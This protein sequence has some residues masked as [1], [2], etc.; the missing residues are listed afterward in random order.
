[1]SQLLNQFNVSNVTQQLKNP[2]VIV[3]AILVLIVLI[4]LFIYLWKRANNT[5]TNACKKLS[6]PTV[7]I[8]SI[9]AKDLH[10]HRPLHDYMIKSSYNSC[11]TGPFKHSWVSLCALNHVIQQGCRVLDFEIYNINGVPHVAASSSVD[12]FEKG[13]YNSIPFDTVIKEISTNA[14]VSRICPNPNDPLFLN[15]RI[16]STHPEIY[17]KMADSLAKYLDDRMLSNQYSYEY[18]KDGVH[19]NLSNVHLDKLVGKVMIMVDKKNINVENSRLFEYINIAGNSMFMH[20]LDSDTIL[21]DNQEETIKFN[22]CQLTM[23][24]PPLNDRVVNYDA[25][26]IKGYGVQMCAMCFQKDYGSDPNL[27]AYINSFNQVGHAFILKDEAYR[28]ICEEV[29]ESTVEISEEVSY[30]PKVIETP[31]VKFEI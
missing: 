29:I 4:G 9:G 28:G 1:M 11:A 10:Y 19:H 15:F 18:L 5:E 30:K 16:K 22:K 26:V 2:K 24:V 6:L 27:H 31:L 14:F 21:H 3:G 20:I 12:F 25:T 23:A 8:S 13:T 17:D 7:T